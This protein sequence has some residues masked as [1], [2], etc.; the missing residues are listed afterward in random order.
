MLAP[1]L[2]V[3]LGFRQCCLAILLSFSIAAFILGAFSPLVAFLL[4]NTPPVAPDYRISGSTYSFIML[5]HVAIIA[6]AGVAANVRLVHLLGQFSPT[7]A[8]ARRVL[9]AWLAGNLFLGSQVCWILRPFIGAP[10]LP[11]QFLRPNALQ[12]NF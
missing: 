4:W 7:K 10:E 11:V 1:L 8:V 6:F 2:G 3:N 5:T 12:G 9:L